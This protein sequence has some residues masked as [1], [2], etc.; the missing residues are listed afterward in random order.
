[1]ISKRFTAKSNLEVSTSL[2]PRGAPV[3]K[4]I[5]LKI[6]RGSTVAIVGTTGSGKTTLINLIPRIRQA[7][8]GMVFIDG[9]R[10]SR[11]ATAPPEIKRWCR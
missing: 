2:I 3:L 11:Y 7:E 8:R 9:V 1:M 5:N 4:N 10:Y 6:P